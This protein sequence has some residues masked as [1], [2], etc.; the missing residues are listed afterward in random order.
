MHTLGGDDFAFLA[1]LLRRRSGL[2]LTPDKAGLF[3]RRLGPVM[4]RFGFKTLTAL[5]RQLR[6]GQEALAAAV[7][8]AMTVNETFFFRD[9]EQFAGLRDVVLPRLLA[10]RAGSKHL[11]IWSAASAAGQEIYSL[12]ML[13]DEMELAAKGW[14]IE[15]I[16]TDISGEA[17]ARA[18]RGHY[19]V[20]EVQRGLSL[21]RLSRYFGSEAYG[22][23]II[24]E[25]LRRMVTFRRFN[26]LDS[27][28]WLDGLDIVLCRNVL[29]YFD[30]ATRQSVLE[31]CA[32]S[33]SEDAVLLLGATES[34]QAVTPVFV[35]MPEAP[36]FHVRAKPAPSR[37][38]LAI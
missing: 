25:R 23:F 21:E 14:N 2:V 6:L 36:G 27:F 16:A 1:R 30:H 37:L 9:P 15:L 32:D 31:R 7:T 4:A 3:E 18:E 26:L 11:R 35:D 22:G 17:V 34:P 38:G 33:M 24:A 20:F 5:V 29:I 13:L 28:G 19:S 12:A 10:A 8:E